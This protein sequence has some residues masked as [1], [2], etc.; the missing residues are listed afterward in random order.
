M[1]NLDRTKVQNLA[2]SEDRLFED[3]IERYE[4][5]SEFQDEIIDQIENIHLAQFDYVLNFNNGH[6]T[7]DILVLS[8][9]ISQGINFIRGTLFG[10]KDGNLHVLN[11]SLVGYIRTIAFLHYLNLNRDNIADSL[12][13]QELDASL[14][15][16]V[17]ALQSNYSRFSEAYDKFINN[18]DPREN[19]VFLNFQKDKED[20]ESI[21]FEFSHGTDNLSRDKLLKLLHELKKMNKIFLNEIEKKHEWNAR[22]LRLP[23][24]DVFLQGLPYTIKHF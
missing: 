4:V 8:G 11:S 2:R 9:L 7:K 13:C 20:E 21:Q 12:D 15:E 18:I 16:M 3:I 5:A 17:N 19:S 10:L 14:D 6:F 22:N 1:E 23:G 24:I